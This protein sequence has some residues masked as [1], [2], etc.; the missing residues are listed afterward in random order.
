INDEEVFY[1]TDLQNE[2]SLS[3]NS[4]LNELLD[5]LSIEDNCAA[6]LNSAIINYFNDIDQTIATEEALTDQQIVT[7]IQNKERDD[8]ESGS[9]DSN[10]K[11][12]E[13]PIQEAYNALKTWITFFEQQQSSNFNMNDIKIFKKYEKI[14]NRILLNSQKQ[15]NS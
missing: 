7:L 8:V 6:A 3:E 5:E 11:P 15:I 4:E 12:S 13:V 1:T 14:T 10:K 2:A 9:D